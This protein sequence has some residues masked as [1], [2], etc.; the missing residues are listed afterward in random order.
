MRRTI[1]LLTI[2]ALGF[3]LRF[4]LLD[5]RPLGFTWDEAALGYNA[6][7]LLKTGRD[8]YG[9][10]L[11]IVLKSFG[12]YK[13]GLY[14]YY[15]VP[16]IA[17][18]GLN[19]FATRFP[20][21]IFGTLLIIVVYLLT[22]NV[23]AALLLAIMPWAIHFSRG[24]WEA[25]LAL[26]LTTLAALL[27]VK[28]RYWLSMLFF[29]LTFWSYQG[30]KMFTPLLL[31]SLFLIYRPNIKLLIKPLIFLIFLIFPV[32]LGFS[33][34]SGRLK[35]FSVFSYTRSVQTI[36]EIKN[37]DQQNSWIFSLFHSE[38]VDQGRGII[39]RY[40]NHLSPYYLFFAGDWQSLRHSIPYYGYLHIPEIVTVLIGLV[41]LL[42]TNSR[43]T[44]LLIAWLLLAPLPAALSRDLVSGVRSLPMVVPLTIISGIGLSVL[45]RKRFLLLL[46]SPVL[47]FSL[48]Y[49]LDLYFVH[50]PNFT[51]ADFL[52]AYRPALQLI[53]PLIPNYKKIVITS[54]F[55][56]P[57]I[58]ILFYLQIDPRQYQPQAHLRENS[59]GDVGEVNKFDK[60]EF[61]PIFWPADRGS[62]STLFI[63]G[64]YELPESDLR[65]TPNLER[66]SDIAFPNGTHALRI[67]GLK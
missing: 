55:G 60:F 13:P 52:Y 2:I 48:F 26:F 8:E 6:Y 9:K 39:Q 12:D 35:V 21:A 37:Q 33:S 41:V 5:K 7:S 38:I 61:R 22:R 24:A 25:N 1:I 54:Q 57:Y 34:Q 27:F 15:T 31:V 47:I 28:K 58:F 67:V 46:F 43:L 14:A 36:A 45:A 62:S 11:P 16:S 19:E 59:Q 10:I 56:Q 51:A 32:L 40:L 20:S 53:K 4:F 3:G 64:Q 42:K 50:S 49:F 17:V 66:I 18:L 65:T 23:F 63:G 29:G 44:K 30:A